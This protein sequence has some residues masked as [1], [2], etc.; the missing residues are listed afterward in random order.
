MNCANH[1][2]IEKAAFCRTCGKP[3]CANCTR[4][5]KGVVYCENCIAE[6]LQGVQPPQTVY[7]GVVDQGAGLRAQPVPGTGPHPPV[8]GILAGFFPFGVGAVYTG[9]YAKGLAHLAIF[10]LLIVGMGQDSPLD[11]IC[12]LGF[13]F[14]Y[15]YQ[16]I[17]SVRSAKAIQSGQPA[18]DPFGLAQAFGAAP[19]GLPGQPTPAI[20]ASE[21]TESK[22]PSAAVLLIGLG[23]LFLLQ[24]AGVFEFN[25][26]RL[27]PLILIGLGLWLFAKRWG[28]IGSG[29]D[30]R[31]RS[32]RM[33]GLT[34]PAVLVTLGFLLFI[35]HF[36]HGPSFHRTWPVL[37]LVIGVT[38][39]LERGGVLP[40]PPPGMGLPPMPGMGP[41]GTTSTG[42]P[43]APQASASEVKN[44]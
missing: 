4:E 20:Q 22:I 5:V 32:Y 28:V 1:P 27:W 19:P 9:Q 38:K 44:G 34:G 21:R 23:L 41:S 17:D 14:F 13:A 12:G 15:V 7:Q 31:G 30:R 10:V 6:R 8:A 37:L 16:I 40:P 29:Y 25:V 36:S 2:D 18:P 26:D 39:L 35:E 24:T 33:R 42:S 3:L 11:T 43:P